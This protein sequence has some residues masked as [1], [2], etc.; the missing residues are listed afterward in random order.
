MLKI[1]YYGLKNLLLK[2]GVGGYLLTILFNG[3]LRHLGLTINALETIRPYLPEFFLVF[4]ILVWLLSHNKF[5]RFDLLF[6]LY[7]III[8]VISLFTMPSLNSFFSVIRDLLEPFLILTIFSTLRLEDI[9]TSQLMKEIRLI[10]TIF[11]LIGFVFALQQYLLGWEWTSKYF[12]GYSF[13]GVNQEESLRIS[14]GWLGFKALGTT[15]SAETFGFYSSLAMLYLIYFGFKHKLANVLL[16][17]VSIFNMLLSGMKTPLLISVVLLF[18]IIFLPKRKS[19]NIFQQVLICTVGLIIFLYLVLVNSSWEES[20][21][22]A[23]LILWKDLLTWENL[24]NILLPHNMYYYA[25]GAENTGIIGF[26]DNSYFYLLFSIGII[27][28]VMVVLYFIR[29][30]KQLRTAMENKYISYL[31][32]YTALSGLTTCVFFGRNFIAIEMMI[33]GFFSAAQAS[34]GI[35][36]EKSVCNA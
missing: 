3:Y 26:W 1:R 33:I 20:S 29:Y 14:T 31:L 30:W 13:W 9:S 11:L 16:V 36:H 15:G 2:I 5:T 24:L 8:G 32:L 10:F 7:F 22:Y 23:R 35:I 18:A 6:W 4:I 27:G 12:A 21:I 25:A 28:T 17:V 34:G 19:M